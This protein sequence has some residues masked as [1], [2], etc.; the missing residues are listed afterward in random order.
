MAL[1]HD[2]AIVL[3]RLDYSETSQVLL[4]FCRAHGAQRMIAKGIKR[5]TKRRVAV[6][7]DLLERGTVVFS[8]R[9][10]SEALGTLTEWRQRDAYPHLRRD[11]PR[12]YAAQYAAEAAAHLTEEGDPHPG[13]FDATIALLESLATDP[14]LAA[15]TRWLHV[16]LREIGLTPEWSRCAACGRSVSA[17]E[18]V[19]FSSRQGGIVCRDCEPA[20][21]EKRRVASDA[22]AALRLGAE[23][24]AINGESAMQDDDSDSAETPRGPTD[25][26]AAIAA[27]RGSTAEMGAFEVLDYHLRET[28][29]RPLRLAQPLKDALR[30]GRVR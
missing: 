5:G 19:F 25:S 26:K 17:A 15:L 8:R 18:P 11:L 30:I 24:A 20:L 7:V 28:L 10:G 6:G 9:P 2:D 13:L 16:L 1:I 21:V 3:R 29:A 23:Q 12:W 27:A 22:L 4:V 14:S